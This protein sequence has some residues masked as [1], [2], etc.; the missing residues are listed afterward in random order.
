[1]GHKKKFL[2][3]AFQEGDDSF[4]NEIIKVE[5]NAFSQ[6]ILFCF[7]KIK[8]ISHINPSILLDRIAGSARTA[9]VRR[10]P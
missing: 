6:T 4:I 10:S 2:D 3:H 5:N 7:F 1:M 9:Q 8:I